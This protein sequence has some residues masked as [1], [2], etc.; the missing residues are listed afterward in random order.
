[1]MTCASTTCVAFIRQAKRSF[2]PITSNCQS[3]YQ[4]FDYVILVVL[5]LE[6]LDW[7]TRFRISMGIAYCLEHM[8]QLKAPV[9]PRI[10]DLTTIYAAKVSALLLHCSRPEEETGDGRGCGSVEGDHGAGS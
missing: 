4:H 9:I 5:Q 2:G 1:M 8:H 10:F 6:K 3:V 7:V